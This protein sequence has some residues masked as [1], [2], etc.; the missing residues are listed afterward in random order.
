[1]T[2]YKNEES[3][4]N[5]TKEKYLLQL[6][7]VSDNNHVKSSLVLTYITKKSTCTFSILDHFQE[8]M[9]HILGDAGV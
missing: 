1:M 8:D 5:F 4:D 6:P 7:L 9:K 3:G 2:T